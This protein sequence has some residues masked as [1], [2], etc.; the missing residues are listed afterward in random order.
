MYTPDWN[1]ETDCV[2]S[3]VPVA[4]LLICTVSA[5]PRLSQSSRYSSRLYAFPSPR[6]TS[7]VKLVDE[8]Q[9][10]ATRFDEFGT[11]SARGS[12]EAVE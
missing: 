8:N 2:L 6:L 3:T 5:R 10:A 9:T 4:T 11:W 1:D 7:T 12:V